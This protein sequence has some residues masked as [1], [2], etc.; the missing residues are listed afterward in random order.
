MAQTEQLARL[1][2]LQKKLYAYAKPLFKL[3][4]HLLA[5]AHVARRAKANAHCVL[6]AGFKRKLGIKCCHAVN[7]AYGYACCG[8]YVM[9][10]LFI[11]AAQYFLRMLHDWQQSALHAFPLRNYA[12][13]LLELFL[14]VAVTDCHER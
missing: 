3:V 11:Y 7:G 9:L 10:H 4:Q 6:S 14:S 12:V 1:D 5:A 13:K 8:A 2:A